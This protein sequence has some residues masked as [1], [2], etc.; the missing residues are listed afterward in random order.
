MGDVAVAV[1][2][3]VTIEVPSVA[4]QEESG[5]VAA[6]MVMQSSPDATNVTSSMS[7]RGGV[8]GSTETSGGMSDGLLGLEAVSVSLNITSP[9]ARSSVVVTSCSENAFFSSFLLT[10]ASV[11][12]WLKEGSS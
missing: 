6:V 9:S 12:G 5:T 3:V 11:G 7:C 1:V 2:V 10:A 8:V 4:A